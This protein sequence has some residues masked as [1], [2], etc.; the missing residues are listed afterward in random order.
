MKKTYIAHVMQKDKSEYSLHY[1]PEHLS[2]VAT[3]AGQYAL[4][5]SGDD[6]ASIAGIWHDLGKFSE[7]FQHY[8]KSA[9][10]YNTE[11]HIEGGT[12][13]GKVNHSDAGA[14]YAVEQFGVYGRI[15][16]YL[17]AGHHA[18]LP[19]WY[20]LDASGGSLQQ[21]LLNTENLNAALAANI[22]P[23]IL[24]HQRPQ[25]PI[26]SG[27]SAGF[28]LWVRMLF[29]CL[30]DA[31]F[32][33]TES[34]MDDVKSAQRGQYPAFETLLPAFNTYMTDLV[35]GADLTDVNKLRAAILQQCRDCA[36]QAPGLFSL[37]VP[38]G[39]GKTLASMAFALEH[40]K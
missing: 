5:F 30:V 27:G 34:F 32:L 19:V 1:L 25:S 23:E 40:A 24:N 12:Q 39:G 18:G 38:T 28:A 33:D 4:F 15:L 8:I 22:P 26:S 11:A 17:I 2:K 35:A 16:A 37:T 20:K 29:S 36:H 13:K 21:R 10:G 3:L 7:A 14:L 9:S 6:W 31:D